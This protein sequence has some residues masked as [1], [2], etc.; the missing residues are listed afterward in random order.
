MGWQDRTGLAG[1]LAGVRGHQECCCGSGLVRLKIESAQVSL[2]ASREQR[3]GVLSEDWT[4]DSTHVACSEW[5]GYIRVAGTDNH[6]QYDSI[7]GQPKRASQSRRGTGD[8]E[9]ADDGTED[10]G[11][12][13]VK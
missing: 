6:S 10:Q 3:V 5:H 1:W 7:A 9:A 8:E 11:E 13:E 4:E 2:A 12:D